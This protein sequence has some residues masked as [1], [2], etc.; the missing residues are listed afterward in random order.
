MPAPKPKDYREKAPTDIG[1]GLARSA[2]QG[3]LFGFGDEV[4]AFARSAIKGADYQETLNTVR[5]E[6]E[7]FRN[8]FS[9]KDWFGLLR[10]LDAVSS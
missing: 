3:L 6:L 10:T 7:E 5:S 2:G 9:I 8:R 4:E 1:L